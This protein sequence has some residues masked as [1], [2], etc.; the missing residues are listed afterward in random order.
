MIFRP[1]PGK[2]FRYRPRALRRAV[3]LIL[4]RRSVLTAAE[5]AGCAY[6]ARILARPGHRLPTEA[7]V[8]STRR[9]LRHLVA[10]GKVESI[11]KA[12]RARALRVHKL[13]ALKEQQ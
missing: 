1:R 8:V 13:Y 7:E 3:L 4:E 10:S 5:V 2:G 6:S 12:R 9:A 11:G